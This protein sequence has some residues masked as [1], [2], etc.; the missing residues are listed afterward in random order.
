MFIGK[1]FVVVGV[2]WLTCLFS[3]AWKVDRVTLD[4]ITR[5]V[6]HFIKRD[7]QR[8]SFSQSGEQTSWFGEVSLEYV[9]IPFS[10]H[11]CV[12]GQSCE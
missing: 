4:W 2:A 5:L 7:D 3:G 12:F 6:V 1:A 8:V 10:I 11:G 9:L